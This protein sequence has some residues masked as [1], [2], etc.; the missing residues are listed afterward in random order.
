MGTA[1]AILMAPDAVNATAI[2]VVTE[3]LWTIAVINRPMKK[4]VN[5]LDVASMIV[6]AAVCP[7]CRSED[8]IRSRA[9]RKI[10]NAIRI[11]AAFFNTTFHRSALACRGS[12]AVSSL[13]TNTVKIGREK[14]DRSS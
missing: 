13:F 4:P 1:F 8:I 7:N 6:S 3:L 11:Y 5:G 2:D 12:I 14:E 9:K 10:N